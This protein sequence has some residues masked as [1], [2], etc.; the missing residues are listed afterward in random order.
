MW[1]GGYLLPILE[2]HNLRRGSALD[3]GCGTGR[4]FE[5][6]L[7]RNWKV[8]GCDLSAGMLK[9]A[10]EKH[11]DRVPL[12][13]ADARDLPAGLSA[14]YA[15]RPDGFELILMLNDVVNYCT[16]DNDL[17][18]AFTGIR[19]NLH[20]SAGLLLF[21]ANTLLLFET[22]YLSDVRDERGEGWEWRGLS[23]KL[24]P[25]G[26]F[27]G[28]LSGQGVESHLHTQ[29][30]WTTVQVSRALE[31]SGL[32]LRAF[33][34]QREDQGQLRLTERPNEDRDEKIIYVASPQ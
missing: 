34:G 6:L 12:F 16:G 31:R 7:R 27:Q 8:V 9:Q 13:K 26:V 32:T 20:A 28:Q 2:R 25:S 1:L 17:E 11:G 3:I 24:A 18:Q 33:L 23:N 14:H 15:S 22:D 19:R 5:P 10:K 29:R 30:H 21:D 4:A